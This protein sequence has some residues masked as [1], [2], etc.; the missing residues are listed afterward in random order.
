MERK[1]SKIKLSTLNLNIWHGITR[2]C[3]YCYS[4]GILNFICQDATNI[5]TTLTRVFIITTDVSRVS[6]CQSQIFITISGG[7]QASLHWTR[8]ITTSAFCPGLRWEMFH[9]ATD[10]KKMSE[11]QIHSLVKIK[12]SVKIVPIKYYKSVSV[13]YLQTQI[14]PVGVLL[15]QQ[16][17]SKYFRHTGWQ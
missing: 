5:V 10:S 4:L 6:W 11:Y 16:D 14:I 3:S 17:L 7:T 9:C 15:L 13:T 12:E 8:N 1:V 2:L